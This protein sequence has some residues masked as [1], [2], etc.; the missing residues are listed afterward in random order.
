MNLSHSS[1]YSQHAKYH[2]ELIPGWLFVH[3]CC[4]FD[5]SSWKFSSNAAITAGIGN[6]R[7]NSYIITVQKSEVIAL[8]YSVCFVQ[9]TWVHIQTNPDV[10]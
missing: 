7:L 9:V 4:S 3:S 8:S 2:L 6:L 5:G 1:V 10:L